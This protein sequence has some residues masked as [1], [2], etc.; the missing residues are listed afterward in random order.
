MAA[1]AAW[2]SLLPAALAQQQAH[3]AQRVRTATCVIRYSNLALALFEQVLDIM[4]D[5]QARS[6]S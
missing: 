5:L 1:F 2:I 3:A 4:H 6:N